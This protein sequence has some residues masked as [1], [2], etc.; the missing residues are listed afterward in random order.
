MAHEGKQ[1]HPETVLQ[2]IAQVS[3]R[4]QPNDLVWVDTGDR[5]GIILGGH[6]LAVLEAFS[7]PVSFS[8]GLRRLEP[9]A[10]GAQDWIELTATIVRLYE[11]GILN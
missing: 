10:A 6:T 7:R 11:V 4:L 8:E 2:R 3:T 5:T 1:L 9:R